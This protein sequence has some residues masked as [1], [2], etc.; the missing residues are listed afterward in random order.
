M[1]SVFGSIFARGGCSK[2]KSATTRLQWGPVH[3][4]ITEVGEEVN[5]KILRQNANVAIDLM[6]VKFQSSRQG[7]LVLTTSSC[8][9]V[10]PGLRRRHEL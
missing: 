5:E 3:L 9:P 1:V 4:T 7:R 10:P 8:S 6:V 2:T